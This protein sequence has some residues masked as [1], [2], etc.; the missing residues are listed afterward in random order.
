V[1][2]PLK[3]SQVFVTSDTLQGVITQLRSEIPKLEAN[4]FITADIEKAAGLTGSS[5]IAAAA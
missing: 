3:H 4:P 2:I 1:I 5:A